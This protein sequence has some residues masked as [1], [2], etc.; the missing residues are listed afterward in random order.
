MK[1]LFLAVM[2]IGCTNLKRLMLYMNGHLP[3]TTVDWPWVEDHIYLEPALKHASLINK[4][5][6]IKDKIIRWNTYYKFMFVRNPL[7]R[8]VSAYRNKIEPPLSYAQLDMFP[9]YLKVDILAQCRADEF[10]SWKEANRKSRLSAPNISVTFSEYVRKYVETDSMYLNE[11]F[12]PSI[13]ICH[14][15]LARFNFYGNFRNFST[16]VK[17]LIQKFGTDPRFYRDESLHSSEE[18]THRKLEEYFRRLTYRDKLQLLGRLYDDLLFY[19][20]LYPSQ[21]HSHYQLL[22]IRQPIL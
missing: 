13:D 19:Y 17:Q 10:Y 15:C 5:L 2:Q 3:L 22:G 6:T 11:H 18:Q 21:R 9:E 14:P 8:L 12:R 1:P 7:E 4:T 20:T 16:D